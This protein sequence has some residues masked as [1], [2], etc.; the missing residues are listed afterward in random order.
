VGWHKPQRQIFEIALDELNAKRNLT[1]YIGDD[2]QADVIGA[3]H[4]GLT[5][6]HV[7]RNGNCADDNC[8]H[9]RSLSKLI[10]ALMDIQ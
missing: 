2:Y 9:I 6:I 4:I 7:D 5:P 8:I 1:C 3:K 10:P